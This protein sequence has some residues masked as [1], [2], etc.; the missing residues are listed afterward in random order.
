MVGM[1]VRDDLAAPAGTRGQLL[2]A[3]QD[4]LVRGRVGALTRARFGVV[5]PRGERVHGSSVA[6]GAARDGREL[7]WI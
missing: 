4:V 6:G 2:D 3:A 5:P 7:T 1:A